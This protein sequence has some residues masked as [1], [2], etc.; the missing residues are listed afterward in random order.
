MGCAA[1]TPKPQ[2]LNSSSASD[3][4]VRLSDAATPSAYSLE[5]RIDPN[6]PAFSG[7]VVIDLQLNARTR[8]IALHGEDMR[9][10]A[11][12]IRPLSGEGA[13][14]EASWSQ[15]HKDGTAVVTLCD[16]CPDLDVG[17]YQLTIDYEADFA[18][19]L[20]GLYRVKYD[21]EWY[22]FTQFEPLA[23]RRAFPS[24]DEPKFKTPFDVTLVV[25]KEH[26]AIANEEAL[27]RTPQDQWQR[28]R[29]KT[30][31]QSPTYL[32]AFAVGPFDILEG[33][34][35][36]PSEWR[37][38]PIRL[39]GIAAK[40]KAPALKYAL[41]AHRE[42][43]L[44]QES[45]LKTGYAFGKIDFIAVPDFQAGAME[46]TGAITYRDFLLLID[47]KTA[48]IDQRRSSL[49]VIA[50][51][52]AH[53]WFGNLVTM[54]WWDDLWLNESFATWFEGR[55]LK[56]IRPQWNPGIGD[57]RG[58]LNVMKRDAQ[59]SARQIR[60]P[61]LST[62]DVRDSF[63]GITY[64]KGSA[65]LTMLEEFL[66]T[67]PFARTIAT[68]LNQYKHG[69]ATASD[70]ISSLKGLSE[71]AGDALSSFI[72]QPGLP[73]LNMRFGCHEN[74]LKVQFEQR[75]F[76][77]IGAEL[78]ESERGWRPPFCLRSNETPSKVVCGYATP[79]A[80]FSLG[81]CDD[82]QVWIPDA[83]GTAYARWNFE[84][85]KRQQ[86]LIE[87]LPNL[88]IAERITVG[89]NAEAL[90]DAGLLSPSQLV[91]VA[92]GLIRAGDRWSQSIAFNWISNWQENILTDENQEALTTWAKERL[93]DIPEKFRT[94]HFDPTEKEADTLHRRTVLGFLTDVAQDTA[95]RT[96]MADLGSAWL[97]A[98]AGSLDLPESFAGMAM[99]LYAEQRSDEAFERLTRAL[100][101]ETDP[102]R[103]RTLLRG[104]S[105]LRGASSERLWSSINDLSLRSNEKTSVLVRN[106]AQ[107]ENRKASWDWLVANAAS[108]KGN[109]PEW[110]FSWLPYMASRPCTAQRSA[111][112]ESIFK[113]LFSDIDGG[114]RSL[115]K[116]RESM[117]QC[118]SLTTRIAAPL[119]DALSKRATQ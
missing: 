117:A 51:E 34:P 79:G 33:E 16:E 5:I 31:E 43:L 47:P 23:A 75:R 101:T 49:S 19:D 90:L 6:Q 28:I 73:L 116:L 85:P 3:A 110:H 93:A 89:S 27:E 86:A 18:D 76:Q 88:N 100:S 59:K 106:G 44:Y 57:R 82:N 15:T 54:P 48:T 98:S 74:T 8:T 53:Q 60:Q 2:A 29:F 22:A 94:V 9:V 12:S 38:Q 112:I 95:A 4:L 42:V 119:A 58:H 87:S 17:A 14:L 24:F 68:Y 84:D 105:A 36:A 56:A 107:P 78:P 103:R 25:K 63:D 113:P 35:I 104:L 114:E 40:G 21:G 37:S 41:D 39:R 111:D 26:T 80:S 66:G 108:M 10:S 13:P 20:D 72:S 32:V 115:K 50:H 77:P 96:K 102:S 67:E 45:Y 83:G 52:L 71:D 91:N 109:V 1:T 97:D 7:R 70:F 99:R 55:T 30:T 64:T 69:H 81:A 65:V 61:V 62:S 11:A 46:N 118:E 92:E